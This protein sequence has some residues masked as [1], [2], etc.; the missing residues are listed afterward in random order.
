MWINN[1]YYNELVKVLIGFSENRVDFDEQRFK[2]FQNEK[3]NKLTS[4]LKDITCNTKAHINTN[5]K[6]MTSLED[7][8]YAKIDETTI[9]DND[10]KIFYEKYNLLVNHH[11]RISR[12]ILRVQ[13]SITEKGKIDSRLDVDEVR[14]K[15][16]DIIANVNLILESLST[17]IEEIAT[18]IN[19]VAIGK[20]NTKMRT[21][22]DNY[23]ISGDFLNIAT[24]I[25]TMV[26]QLATFA[27]E[28]TRVARDVGTEGVL[29]GQAK[30]EGVS[31]TWL[32]LTNNVNGMADNLTAQVRNITEVTTA[33]AKGNL[34]KKITVEAKGEVLELK[35]TINTMV[36]QLNAFCSE[37]TRVAKEVG[38]EGM[39]G[40]QAKVEGV[41]GTWLELTNNVNGMADNLTAQVR[42]IAEV[43]TAV[44]NGDLTK[45]ITVEAKGEILE[46]KGTINTMVEQ[47][48]AFSSEVTRVAKD[49]GTE[50][51]LG[52]QAK[53]EGAS[54][55]WLALT[56][57]VNGMADN[58]TAQVRN[59]AEVTTAVA[60][61]DLTKMITVEAKGEILELK[62]TINKM[63][64]QLNAFSSEV[65]R[66]AKDVGTDGILGGQAKV[67]GVAGTWLDLTNNVN[68][69]ADN[70]T[71][72]VR[73]IAEVTTAVANG[74]LTKK[75]TVEAKG[76]ILELKGTI[77][78][79]V[80]QLNAFSSEVTR[81]AKDVGTEGVLGGQAKVEGA[82]GAWLDLTNNVN[83]MADNLTAQ[84]RN[85]AEVTTAVANGDLTT[86]ITVEAKGEFLQ[87]KGT[88]NKMVAQLNAFSSEVTRVAKDVGTEGV[89]GGLAKVEGASGA[90]LDL[91]N[92]VNGMADNL[93]AQVRNIAEVTTAV[94]NGDLTKKITVE[95]K[96]EILELKGTVN[97]M[98]EQL[99]AFSSEVTRVAKE[100]GN[101]GVLGG[102]AKVEG[103]SG[104]WLDLTNNVNGMADNLT[105]QVRN[106]A[107]VTTAVANGDLT[108]MITVEAKGEI[109][110]LKGTINKMVA[111]L[112]AFSSEVTRVA[113]DVGTEGILGGQAKVEGASGAWLDLTNNVNG[114]A[115][116]LTAQV[117]NIAEVTTAVANGDLTTMITVEAKGEILELKGTINKMVAQLN[118]FSSEVTRVAKDVGTDGIL[119]G[120]AKVE[121]VS[122]TWLKLTNNVNGMA[123]NLTVQVRNITE[124]V[125]AVA[126]GDLTRLIDIDTKGEFLELKNNINR[127]I[128]VLYAADEENKNQNWVKDGVSL[129]NTRV[130]DNDKLVDQIE[131][132]IKE[133]S[134]YVNAGIGALYIYDKENEILN[135]KGSY[136]YVKR[137]DVANVFKLGEGVVGQVAYEKKPILLT[138]VPD[139]STIQS[140]TTKAKALNVYTYPLVFK[141]ELIGVVEVASYEKFNAI[142]LE[143]IDSALITLAGSLYVSIQASATSNLLVQSQTQSVE[144]EEQ[145]LKLKS[146]NNELEEQRQSMDL[147]RYE[148][149]VKNSD[150]ELAQVEVNQRAKDLEDANRYKSEFLANMSH[151]LRT[152]LNSMLLLSSSLSK[153]KDIEPGKL[154]KQASTIYDAGSSLLNLIND[155]LDLSK[156]EANLMTLNIEE[157]NISS[158][159]YELKELFMPQA[160]A[161]NIRLGSTIDASALIAFSSDKTK[162][163][164]VLRNFLSN[165]I[166]F[167][168][169]NGSISIEVAPNTEE[170]KNL[171]PIVISVIDNGIGIE[172]KNIGLVFEAF[173]QADGGTS[174]QYGGTGLGLSISK[175]LTALLGGRIVVKS[176]VSEGSTF[177]I[178][179]P[180]E[181]DTNLMDDRLVEHVQYE[182][183]ASNTLKIE[184][185][186]IIVDDREKLNNQDVVILVVDDDAA[187]ANIV[188]EQIH[189]LGYKAIV[190]SDGNAAIF[191]ARE[192]MPTAI[193]LD[194]VL[195]ILN[196]MEVLRILKSDINT[197][198]IPVKILS[199]NEPLTIAKKLG[200]LDFIKKPIQEDELN[201][202]ITSLVDFVQ[203]KEKHILIIEDDQVQAGHLKALLTDKDISVK[204]VGTAK[205]GLKE[206]T[207]KQYNCAVVD[208]NLP[209]MCGLK[210]LELIEEK[211]AKLP[212]IIYTTRDLTASE[213]LK[214]R[215]KSEAVV[216]K[217]AS[218]DARLVEEVSLFLHSVKDSLNDE[219]QQLLFE[220][221]NTDL[222]LEGKK[223][224]MVDD[225]IRNLYALSSVLEGKGLDIT[226]AQNGQEA[227]ALLKNTENKFD[228]VLMDI[229]MPVM[230]GYEAMREI[231]KEHKIKNIPI[232]ALTAKA[233]AEDKQICIDAGANDYMSKPI[234]HEQLLSLLKVWLKDGEHYQE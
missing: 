103:A 65:T 13:H 82:S 26:D 2:S 200:A 6:I 49:V 39:L 159:L 78:T 230:D 161:K 10:F 163:T 12:H 47:L 157:I 190:A 28:V 199:C 149:E 131:T 135:L 51:V 139:V 228:I 37:V 107:E 165:A 193:V 140:G 108:K 141:E 186:T 83:G 50:G 170:D 54:G 32:E 73:N 218:S 182:N 5:I 18:V 44:A 136:A 88:I 42:N 117:R 99:N 196:G 45:K 187:F 91:T 7:G 198:H 180:I 81:V 93:T 15:W 191:M 202:L 121:G 154:N 33:V 177:S 79:M 207:N 58:L 85:I 92:N 41:S 151:E 90:W 172:E 35:G 208:I 114:M 162:L 229:M 205:N 168:G 123:D 105:A 231:R 156:I 174:R 27:S 203:D 146:Q 197:R 185:K 179:L 166:K 150:L 217:I 188:V 130:L 98:V 138:N 210:L 101:D 106:I 225:D 124:V 181:I 61:G 96:G 120:Q 63:V 74:D 23:E 144:L 173:K 20:L 102:Q 118:A 214:V 76:E 137:N 109:L 8:S 30:V 213:L 216:L 57:N 129:L 3:Y 24:T 204:T 77:N 192:Y 222:G 17:P 34:T 184:E 113:K 167:T 127:M 142:I 59:I 233:Q 70:L 143:Y 169:N 11:D 195:P 183:I 132:S 69:M 134:R 68:G 115:D 147:Q 128:N 9:K 111:Q 60:N 43:T 116:N 25:N 80:E 152:P 119:G 126:T 133:V 234:D 189:K 171:R 52:G 97:T 227:L 36:E 209:D 100:V 86:M 48:N 71:A 110:E 38:N 62:G 72:Q 64:A 153:V 89:L 19:S 215:K 122:G 232:I 29:G 55:A 164:Q 75:I 40:G 1:S 66:V 201:G 148:L 67:E 16:F 160:D 176:I 158:L 221:M 224:L 112:N 95:A 226:S 175:E 21:K 87:L 220:A 212:I 104:A 94:A 4:L 125:T 155:I 206:V 219:K 223:I 178:C 22:I 56:N 14:G 53:V 84:V 194:I 145:S 46:L 211:D 31:G